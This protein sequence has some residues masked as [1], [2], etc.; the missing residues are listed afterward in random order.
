MIKQNFMKKLLDG[1]DVE[2][3]TLSEISKISGAGVDK[4]SHDDEEQILLLNYMEVYRNRYLTKNIPSMEVTASDKKIEQCNI[5][6]GDIFFTPSS[7]VLNDIGNSAVAIE[8]MDGV[9]YSYHIMRLRLNNPNIITSMFISYLLGSDYVQK[10]INKK[11]NG[12][13]RFGLTK[14]Q[15]EK[16]IIPIPC[17]DNPEKSLEIQQEIV[18]ILD[19]VTELTTKLTAELIARKKQYNYY[20]EKLLRFEEGEVEWRLLGDIGKFTRGKRFVKKDIISKGVPCIHYGEMYTYYKVWSNKA[21]SYIDEELALKLRTAK[22]GDVVIV[23]AGE[24]IEDIGIG[25]AWLGEE[26]VVIHD[27]CF[28]YSSNLNPKY[29]AYFSRTRFFNDQI[30]KHISSGKISAINAKGLSKAK[31]PIPYPKDPDKSL[32]EQQRIVSILDK[33]EALTSSITEGLPREIELRQK[34]YEYY[35]DMLLS[36]PKDDVD[37]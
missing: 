20:R 24:T 2:W 25:T 37:V 33:F 21:K 28:F 32:A 23:A 11:A 27:A 6:K 26:N 35:R 14:T 16:L 30:K 4:K 34:Q 7:E 5:L 22:C 13:T 12:I 1:V 36:F 17:P 15:W 9:V 31:I 29:V 19:T 8:D 10:Q 3:L 18:R